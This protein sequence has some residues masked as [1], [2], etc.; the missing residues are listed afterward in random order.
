[1]RIEEWRAE[2][3]GRR[4][5]IGN[6]DLRCASASVRDGIVLFRIDAGFGS[7][8]Y[9]RDRRRALQWRTLWI[10]LNIAICWGARGMPVTPGRIR[11]APTCV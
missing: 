3:R 4:E 2:T 10:A 11:Y 9:L 8:E 6:F 7:S 1:M 5:F